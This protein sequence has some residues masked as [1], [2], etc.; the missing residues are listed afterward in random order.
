MAEN[1]LKIIDQVVIEK[2]GGTIDTENNSWVMVRGSGTEPV[3]RVYC[4]SSEK[5]NIPLI[6]TEFKKTLFE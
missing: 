2:L 3:L 5:K 1:G 4:E 6:M